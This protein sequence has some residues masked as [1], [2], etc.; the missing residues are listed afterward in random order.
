MVAQGIAWE[1]AWDQEAPSFLRPVSQLPHF[2]LSLT[3]QTWGVS[4]ALGQTLRTLNSCR[5]FKIETSLPPRNLSPS[6]TGWV[7]F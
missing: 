6:Y 1:W 4:Q 3:P 5:S 7:A 2:T